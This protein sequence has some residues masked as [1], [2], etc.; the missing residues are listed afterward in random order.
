MKIIGEKIN[1]TR[2]KVAQAIAERNVVHIQDL[3]VKQTE[4]GSTWLD[5]NAGTQPEKEPEDLI[6]LIENI[7]SVTDTPLCLDS[8]NPEA[9]KLA[10]QKAGNPTNKSPITAS[11][12]AKR[13][14]EAL[15]LAFNAEVCSN[16]VA[17]SA[18]PEPITNTI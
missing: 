14:Y 6:W 16:T 8:A 18:F 2:K 12:P 13:T 3:A 9:L 17:A 4:A 10:I 5:V 15:R 11:P 7:Q 1:G